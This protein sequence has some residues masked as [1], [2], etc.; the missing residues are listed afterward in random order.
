LIETMTPR[1]S[2]FILTAALGLAMCSC[3]S[4]NV[5][6]VPPT[7]MAPSG[8][9]ASYAVRLEVRDGKCVFN[10]DGPNKGQLE[11][12][13]LGPCEFLRSPVGN[14]NSV[15]LKNTTRNGGGTYS[16]ILVIGGPPSNEG[17]FDRYMKTG[18]YSQVRAISL[19][20]RGVALG[21]IGSGLDVCPTDRVDE[22][23][24]TA[25]SVHV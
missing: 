9:V 14:I 7:V 23:F 12:E 25:D 2:Y 13:L 19:S 24:F 4:T 10:Y 18:C 21:S 5:A 11:I 6:D 16:V 22:K 3:D 1:F 17:R 20:P 15:E 8:D